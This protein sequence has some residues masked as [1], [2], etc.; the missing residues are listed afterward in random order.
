MPKFAAN[1]SSH[2]APFRERRA[3]FAADP[4]YVWDVL[5]DG[6]RRARAIADETMREVKAAVGLP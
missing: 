5:A 4:D 6:A 3:Q 1:L 2:F